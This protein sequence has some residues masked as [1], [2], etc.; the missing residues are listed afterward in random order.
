MP[1][2]RAAQMSTDGDHGIYPLAVANEPHPLFF[3]QPRTHPRPP[4][5]PSCSGRKLLGWFAQN[6]REEKAER[7]DE[8]S[9]PEG[10]KT[11]PPDIVEEASAGAVTIRR[12]VLGCGNHDRPSFPPVGVRCVS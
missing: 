12:G 1:N 2:R 4:D 10:R 8:A 6:S 11:T 5:S 9:A 3:L 7:G